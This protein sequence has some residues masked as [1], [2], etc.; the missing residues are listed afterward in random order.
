MQEIFGITSF[1]GGREGEEEFNSARVW[2]NVNSLQAGDW[3]LIDIIWLTNVLQNQ[4]H[5]IAF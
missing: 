4:P 1:K 3:G 5:L 2:G